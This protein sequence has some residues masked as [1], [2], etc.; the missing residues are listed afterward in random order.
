MQAIHLGIIKEGKVPPDFRVPLSPKQCQQLQA[1]YPHVKVS[2]QRSPIRIFSDQEYADAGIELVDTLDH[3]DYIFGVKEVPIDKLIANK[4]FVFF[5]HTI[6]KQPYNRGLLQALLAQKIRLIDYEVLRDAANK[7]IIGFGRYAGI[8]GAYN[9][10]LTYGLK[11]NRFSLKPAHTCTDRKEVER[12]LQKV[13]LPS[14]YRVVL[15][16][17][18]RVGHG[19]REIMALLPIK[20]VSPQAFLN[21]RFDEPVF[22][23][24]DTN[25]YFGRQTDGS[26]DKAQFYAQPEGYKSLF[27]AYSQLADMYIPCHFWNAKSPI[28]LSK[29][30]LASPHNRIR[31]VADVS[32]DIDGPVACTIRPSKIGNAIY[33]Y[34][35]Q[36]QSE[37]DF[38]DPAAIAVMAVDNLPCELPKDASEDFGNELLKNVFPSLF[39]P[40]PDAIIDRGSETT[41]LGELNAPFQY[42]QAY[43]EG[44][45]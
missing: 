9:A 45:E 44:R 30:M 36:L 34:H 38:Q 1:L 14:N 31:V 39:G 28:I 16:G 32:C 10:F 13:E 41:L 43:V 26:F 33:G 35:P 23:H 15:T 12:E 17:F 20:E 22:T 37:C 29:E 6:K 7:R 21:E 2:V 18:G 8:V 42:L 3:C 11:S 40:D 5:S 25:D 24:L 4:T 27:E 19:A